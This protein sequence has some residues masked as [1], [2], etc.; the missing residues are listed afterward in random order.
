MND[1][2][3]ASCADADM[4]QNI[5]DAAPSEDGVEAQDPRVSIHVRSYRKLNHDPDGVSIKAALDGIVGRGILS[6]DSTKQIKE[7]TLESFTGHK[8]ERTVIE[9]TECTQLA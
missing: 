4:E 9:I 3:R 5:G 8:E 1:K 6:D 7:I 2:T